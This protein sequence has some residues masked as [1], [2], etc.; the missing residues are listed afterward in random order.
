MEILVRRDN[1]EGRIAVQD[2]ELIR[3]AYKMDLIEKRLLLLAIS[4]INSTNAPKS[5]AC[6]RV[7]ITA[8]DWAELYPSSNTWRDLKQSCDRLMNRQVTIRPMDRRVSRKM[9]WVDQCKYYEQEGR[10]EISFG[11]SISLFLAGMLDQF[12]QM[13]L[14]DVAKFSSKHTVRTFEMLSQMRR[15]GAE[16]S[17]LQITLDEYR[18]CLGIDGQYPAFAD[19]KKRILDP[20]MDELRHKAGMKIDLELIKTG[21]KVSALKFIYSNQ[22]DLF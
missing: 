11:Y 8:R 12:T 5:N 2:N 22:M 7:E 10:I 6:I 15:D 9:Q 21:R 1:N 19:V 4:K 20:V 17:W 18:T 16:E 3:A 14:L 13:D